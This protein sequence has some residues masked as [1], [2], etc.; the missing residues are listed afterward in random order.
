M[1]KF[2]TLELLSIKKIE[3]LAGMRREE[4]QVL[5]EEVKE[6]AVAPKVVDVNE[7]VARLIEDITW[8]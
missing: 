8:P 2:C 3:G 7:K 5:V 6:A 1:R 4:V